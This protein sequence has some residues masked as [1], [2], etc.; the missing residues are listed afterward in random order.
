[1]DLVK[2]RCKQKMSITLQNILQQI[3][4]QQIQKKI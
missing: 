1:M 2:T 4:L 3:Q